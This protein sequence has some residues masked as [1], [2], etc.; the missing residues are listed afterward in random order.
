MV[1]LGS[2]Y[3]LTFLAANNRIYSFKQK[4][5]W[6]TRLR[7]RDQVTGPKETP[8]VT[9]QGSCGG[10]RRGSVHLPP[11]DLS[12]CCC[13][14]LESHVTAPPGQNETHVPLSSQHCF[15]ISDTCLISEP[16]TPVQALIVRKAQR[17]SFTL[18]WIRQDTQRVKSPKGGC[19]RGRG[20]PKAR[21]MATQIR[22]C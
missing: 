14:H 16:R 9:A 13:R 12:R 2:G 5:K 6:F 17:L 8:T 21:K 10:K 1:N 15:Q 18:H 4:N 7:L 22:E 20:A 3:R 11:R 19:S